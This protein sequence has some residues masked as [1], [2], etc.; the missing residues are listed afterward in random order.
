MS[1]PVVLLSIDQVL[2]LHEELIR[3]YGGLLAIRDRGLLESALAMPG[4]SFGGEYLHPTIP[5]MAAAY[6]FH[7]CRNHPFVDGNKRI[8]LAAA[9]V[10]LELNGA[11]LAMTAEEKYDITVAVASGQC[12]KEQLTVV[13]ARRVSG[14]G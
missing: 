13:F 1:L 8:A 4:A 14:I 2:E 6:L 9:G 11:Q 12:S 7:L 3:R 10:F 5:A